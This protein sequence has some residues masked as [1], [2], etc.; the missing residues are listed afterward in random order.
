MKK[1]TRFLINLEYYAVL[2]A[3]NLVNILPSAISLFIGRIIGRLY[4]L[5]D[6]RHRRRAIQHL[7]HAKITDDPREACKIALASFN[8]LA[9]LTIEIFTIYKKVNDQNIKEY[10][11]VSGSQEAIDLF[12]A[13][14]APS[15]AILVT[16][17]YGNWELIPPA[18]CLDIPIKISGRGE[19]N[20]GL[21]T[22]IH[23]LS[24]MRP[25]DNPKLCDYFTSTRQGHTF[26]IVH[27]DG[28]LRQLLTALK[29]GES[30]G[31]LADQHASANEGV[32]TVFF[33]HP[34]S[35]HISP[36]RLHL[37]TGVPILVALMRRRADQRFRYHFVCH[38][39]I[40]FTPT[41]DLDRDIQAVAQQYTSALEDLIR[42]DPTQWTWAHRRWKNLNR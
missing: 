19:N 39:P 12:F 22:S 27:K 2:V 8:N 14:E 24:I 6:R 16:G 4:F 35:A 13:T 28:A 7:L 9:R 26:S 1:K 42:Q 41:G 32:E 23:L 40:I 18:Y 38:A 34:A 15:P 11:Q 21:L 29:K 31:M 30:I 3:A 5:L 17:H 10:V 33:G 20:R 25:F 36:A 37:K